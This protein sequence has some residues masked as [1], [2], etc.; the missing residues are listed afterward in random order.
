MFD[1]D[2]F[3]TECKAALSAPEP[4]LVVERLLREAMA[5]VDGLREALGGGAEAVF[6]PLYRSPELTVANMS[7]APGSTSPIHNH[8]MWGVIGVYAGQED[9]FLY[10][11][12]ANG[13]EQ[14]GTKSL[15]TADVYV[16]PT[17]LIH[18][19]NNPLGEFNAAL[20]VYGGDLVERPGRSIWNPESDEEEDYDIKQILAYTQQL[21]S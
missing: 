2:L 20:H 15:R 21:S 1:V 3:V 13:L 16:M 17:D 6:Q 14:V 4:K 12:G 18:A 11:R 5:D 8:C 9:N 10:Q 19:I 7:T